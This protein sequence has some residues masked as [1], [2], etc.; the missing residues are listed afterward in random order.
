MSVVVQVEQL[1]APL[2]YYSQRIFEECNDDQ[3]AAEGWEVSINCRSRQHDCSPSRRGSAVGANRGG[4][5]VTECEEENVRFHGL[6]YSVQILLNLASLLFDR[7][8]RTW[9]VGRIVIPWAAKRTLGAQMVARSSSDLGHGE[10]TDT[11]GIDG[12]M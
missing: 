8:E 11:P 1:V 3:E 5:L 9:I 6:R 7:I 2:R 10:E 12:A 4:Q